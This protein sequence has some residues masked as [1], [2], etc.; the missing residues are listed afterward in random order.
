[1]KLRQNF[2]PCLNFIGFRISIVKTRGLPIKLNIPQ[3]RKF[4]YI[5][6]TYQYFYLFSHKIDDICQSPFDPQW[7]LHLPIFHLT[8]IYSVAISTSSFTLPIKENQK[9][10]KKGFRIIIWTYS[11]KSSAVLSSKRL[12]IIFPCRFSG[13]CSQRNKLWRGALNK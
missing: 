8:F 13:I 6:L 11:K 12:L 1:M 2:H 5:F 4:H 7:N 3:Q 9:F 10:P